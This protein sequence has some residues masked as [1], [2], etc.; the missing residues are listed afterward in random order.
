MKN[1]ILKAFS[2]LGLMTVILLTA[3]GSGN[4]PTGQTMMNNVC[5]NTQGLNGQ[6]CALGQLQSTQYGCLQTNI[7]GCNGNMGWSPQANSCVP[8]TQVTQYG[9]QTGYGFNQYPQQG[10]YPSNYQQPYNAGNPNGAYGSAC[11]QGFTYTQMSGCVP[12]GGCPY[13][14]GM[15]AYG[16]S[17]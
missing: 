5:T 13:G 17:R 2:G 4:C 8:G 3:C 15:T 11:Q 14:M 12:Q 16:C 10:Q 6:Q 1:L 7:N 9:Q